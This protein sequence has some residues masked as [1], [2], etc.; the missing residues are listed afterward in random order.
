MVNPNGPVTPGGAGSEGSINPALMLAPVVG[1]FYDT[2]Q[3]NK[4]ARENTEKTIA[5][6]KAEAELAYQRQVEM[7][8]MQN[9]YNSP[10]EQMKRFGAAGLNPHLIYG[11]GNA[12][13]AG[14]MPQ[15][16]APNLQ[17]RYA[18][19]TY[20]AG[21]ASVLPTLMSVGTWMQNMRLTDAEIAAKQTNTQKAEQLIE[22]LTERNPLELRRLDNTLS[23]YPYQRSMLHAKEQQ[24]WTAWNQ[25]LFEGKHRYGVDT[26]SLQHFDR[27]GSGVGMRDLERALKSKDVELRGLQSQY[28][29]PA[30]IMKLVLGGVLGMT[31]LGRAVSTSGRVGQSARNAAKRVKTFYNEKGRRRSQVVDYE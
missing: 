19:P 27:F 29:E 2:Y 7:W 11:Q 1:Q 3:T 10:A 13:N 22:F 8:H 9:A 25:L 4:T 15:Y 24:A 5:A 23:L 18:A 20:G 30:M 6:Q 28:Y 12:G 26:S 17:Y 21:V 16:H 14:S 31:G